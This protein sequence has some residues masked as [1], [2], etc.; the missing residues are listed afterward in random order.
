MSADVIV[1]T[2]KTPDLRSLLAGLFAGGP[3]LG[4][5]A[6]DDGAVLRL[7]DRAGRPL[8]SVEAPL[9]VHTPGEAERLL[10]PD[11]PAPPVPYWWTEIRASSA[12]PEAEVLARSVGGRLTTLLGGAVWPRGAATT[13]SVDVS[14]EPAAPDL[15]ETVDVLTESTAVVLSDRPVLALTTWLADILRT[16]ATAGRALHLV[17][18]ARARLTL[19]LRRALGGAPNRWVVRDPRGGYYDGLSGVPLAWQGGTFTPTGAPVADAYGQ[20]SGAGP[21]HQLTVTFRTVHAPDA[22]LTLGLG[23]ETAWRHLTGAPPVGWGTAEP[24]NLPWSPHQVTDLARE[25]S[26]APTHLVAAGAPDRPAVATLRVSRTTAGVAQDVTLTAGY[27]SAADV[28][29]DAVE[30]L[31]AHLVD[32]H[33]LT[34]MLTTLRAARADLTV[35][36]L[37]EGPPTPLSFTLGARDV[38][39]IGLTRAL[40][41]PDGPH[42]R[43]LGSRA[44]PAVHYLLGDGTS[45]H[46]RTV[47]RNLTAHLR[48]ASTA[49]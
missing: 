25:R 44:E 47:L 22:G 12:A 37:L 30:S 48:R 16:S 32:E 14:E 28:P 29:L 35:P 8:V 42:T 40:H 3:E 45:T 33:H 39:A 43:Q 24:V 38:S 13:R 7:C 15:P 49:S 27:A 18:P 23:L 1:L 20:P 2:P 4:L 19:P 17:T 36:P 34:T 6:A 21:G 10:G 41:A 46:S 5:V 26:P 31:A 9:L 11:V